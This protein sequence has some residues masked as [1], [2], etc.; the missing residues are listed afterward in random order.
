M[1]NDTQ[2]NTAKQITILSIMILKTPLTSTN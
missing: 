2:H 1:I